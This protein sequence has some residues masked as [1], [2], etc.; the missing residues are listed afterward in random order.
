MAMG[1][2]ELND[3]IARFIDK[4]SVLADMAI[5]LVD[6]DKRFM[7]GNPVDDCLR[8]FKQRQENYSKILARSN[9]Y[10]NNRNT[11]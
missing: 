4:L 6:N 1:D 2:Q 11:V 10:N 3:K 5:V 9:N 7:T 8:R